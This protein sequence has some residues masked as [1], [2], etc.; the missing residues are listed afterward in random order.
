MDPITAAILGA[1]ATGLAG[2]LGDVCKKMITDSY[3]AIKS[4]ITNKLGKNHKVVDAIEKLETKPNSV[5][6]Q[7]NLRKEIESAKIA[8]D[9]EIKQLSK[10]LVDYLETIPEGRATL[11]KFQINADKVGVVTENAHIKNLRL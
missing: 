4:V 6:L 3:E 5:E 1:L 9:D 8:E 10:S 7:Q 2:G 11:I